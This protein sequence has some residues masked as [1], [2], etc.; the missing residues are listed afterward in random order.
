MAKERR[1]I[2]QSGVIPYRF[3]GGRLEVLVITSNDGQRWGMP[4]GLIE[5]G[6]TPAESAAKEAFEEAGV[7]G[8]LG[9]AVGS[10]SFAKWGGTCW[11]D[12]FLLRVEEILEQWEEQHRTREWLGV[13]E[14]VARV[15]R[16]ELGELVR[17]VPVI[18]GG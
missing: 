6:L 5:P 16:A 15:S 17:R 18:V 3:H 14:A 2:R 13:E 1:V 12:V 11:V 7:R 8:L 9:G 10:Y 4:K